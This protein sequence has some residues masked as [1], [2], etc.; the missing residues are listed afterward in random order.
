MSDRRPPGRHGSPDP[1]HHLTPGALSVCGG[2]GGGGGETA[3]TPTP[4]V[5][6]GNSFHCQPLSSAA[7]KLVEFV[8][9]DG[10]TLISLLRHFRDQSSFI[11][12]KMPPLKPIL[13]KA[14]QIVTHV[15]R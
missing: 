5:G 8:P 14:P 4:P 2:G 13:H 15:G 7:V 6:L 1:A 10:G 9:G 12:I 11:D 3:V